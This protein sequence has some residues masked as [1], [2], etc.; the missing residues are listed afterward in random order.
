MS[1]LKYVILMVAGIIVMFF[2]GP[3]VYT[4]YGAWSLILNPILGFCLGWTAMDMGDK[5]K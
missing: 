1:I 5:I 3:A 2:V 4:A